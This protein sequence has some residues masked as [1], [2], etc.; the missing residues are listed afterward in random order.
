MSESTAALRRRLAELDAVIVEQQRALD[1]L[2]RERG[3]VEHQLHATSIFP[4]LTLPGEITAEI[5]SHCLPSIE[6]LRQDDQPISERLESQAPTVFLG[7]CRVWKDI[8]LGTP[9]LW[10][11][12]S[13]RFDYIA[14]NVALEPGAV[15]EFID[16]WLGRAAILPLSFVF[17]TIR[18]YDEF[19]DGPFTPSRMRDVIHRY[20]HRLE[21]IELEMSQYDIDQLGLHSVDF[22]LLRRAAVGD[23]FEP[24][25]D[26]SNPVQIYSNASQLRDLLFFHGTIFSS[27]ILP[28]LQLSKFV[29]AIQNLDLFVLAPNLIEAQCCVEHLDT[30]LTTPILHPRLQYLTLWTSSSGLFFDP[31]PYLTLPALHSLDISDIRNPTESLINFLNRSSSPP[32]LRTISARI[33]RIRFYHWSRCFFTVAATLENLECHSPDSQ[34]QDDLFSHGSKDRHDNPLPRLRTLH[35]VD[36]IGTNYTA[37]V[38]FLRR[39]SITPTLSKIRSF[40]LIS[41]PGTFLQDIF[42]DDIGTGFQATD[43][44]SQLAG[45]GT[46]IHIGTTEKAYVNHVQYV[47]GDPA[48]KFVH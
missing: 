3:D 21:Y 33:E 48:Y 35:F 16:M 15:E 17:C 12:L 26:S 25:P 19:D 22:P 34:F 11:T 20:A 2:Q 46:D 41:P 8:A 32:P 29:G 27:Y 9:A 43:H 1:D 24:R 38:V 36:T 37:L 45:E 6:E 47:P 28:S 44:L 5:F 7:V 4:V 40:R 39:R 14:D 23:N 42:S 10:A 31:F 18:G 13:L 30:I